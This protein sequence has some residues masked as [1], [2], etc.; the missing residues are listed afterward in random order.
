[1]QTIKEKLDRT[2]APEIKDAVEF[3]LNLRPYEKFV[4]RNGVVNGLPASNDGP[5]GACWSMTAIAP[6]ISHG[7]TVDAGVLGVV[8]GDKP[9]ASRMTAAAQPGASAISRNAP[10]AP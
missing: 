6:A 5:P 7:S 4:L 10:L 2:Q 9:L 8:F 3:D 1:M